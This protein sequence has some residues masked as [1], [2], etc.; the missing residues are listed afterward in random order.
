MH[1]EK[2]C[3][4]YHEMPRAILILNA[5]IGEDNVELE[6]IRAL[7]YE[8][9]PAENALSFKE[10]GNEMVKERRWSDGKEFYTKAI[11]VLAQKVGE[12]QG[13]DQSGAEDMPTEREEERN[14]EE[15]CYVNRALCN[16]ELKNY[17]S[18]TLDCASALRLNARNVKAY[19]R[20][21]QALLALDKLN[22][23]YDACQHGLSVDADNSALDKLMTKIRARV[24]TVTAIQQK[25]TQ[26][27][28]RHQREKM[29]LAAALKAREL[30][31]R[32]TAQPP[33]MEDASIHLAPDPLS[34]TSSLHFPVLLLYPMHAQSDFIKAFPETDTIPQHLDY[35]LPLPWDTQGQYQLSNVEL[36]METSSG[37]LI[38]VGKNMS[39]LKV[40]SGGD[41]EIVDELVKINVLPK[42]NARA[43]I[44]EMKARKG[45]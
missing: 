32:K 28:Q 34:P 8:G 11:V 42:Q 20:S 45:R 29:S 13:G 37:G 14:I 21:S 33:E 38:K 5:R 10:Q 7:Q 24:E 3:P 26:E 16:L 27:A 19:Y 23:A 1:P 44:E 2:V 43:W 12:Q 22:E 17:R 39:L 6:A 36:F 30:R 18:T 40:L 4:L 25:K 15:A 9:T 41:I 31:L 35:I